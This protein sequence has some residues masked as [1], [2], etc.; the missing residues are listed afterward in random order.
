MLSVTVREMAIKTAATFQLTLFRMAILRK[1]CKDSVLP[2]VRGTGSL[3]TVWA[4]REM[5][6]CSQ[7]G[8]Q[9]GDSL[10]Q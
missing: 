7:E 4:R 5:G 8:K 1:I 6:G 3:P 9:C 2:R 10:K